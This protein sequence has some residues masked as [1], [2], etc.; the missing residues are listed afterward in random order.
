MSSATPQIGIAPAA[1]LPSATGRIR[2]AGAV[3]AATGVAH[4]IA[5]WVF[6]LITRPLF[7][8]DTAGW[9][10]RN[11]AAETVIGAALVA[12]KTRAAG[13]SGLAVYAVFLTGRLFRA[14]RNRTRAS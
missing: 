7:P 9:I 1:E 5:P 11:G 3:L 14:L 2:F 8:D 13:V 6:D 12:D 4:F 10:R